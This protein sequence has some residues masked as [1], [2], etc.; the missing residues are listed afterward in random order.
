[1]EALGPELV[2]NEL[3]LVRAMAF[4][5]DIQVAEGTP[6][7][8][9][10][11]SGDEVQ[12][13]YVAQ[14]FVGAAVSGSVI[15]MYAEAAVRTQEEYDGEITINKNLAESNA[16]EVGRRFQFALLYG[17]SPYLSAAAQVD[18]DFHDI[19]PAANRIGDTSNFW[20]T[21]DSAVKLTNLPEHFFYWLV[22]IGDGMGDF[23]APLYNFR[24]GT[25][26]GGITFP[27]RAVAIDSPVSG[28]RTCHIRLDEATAGA[29][30][31]VTNTKEGE[32]AV[33]TG[34]D[35][36]LILP[37]TVV[38]F[39]LLCLAGAEFYRRKLNKRTDK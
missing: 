29:E 35:R 8:I 7:P 12:D 32:K 25:P 5:P 1:M 19:S 18:L 14:A 39:G 2:P 20:I 24:S 15:N 23:V 3:L 6:V 4:A 16:D 30:I 26:E 10:A 13:W 31:I 37:V 38:S 22:E 33:Q 36:N 34:D 11:L 9:A 27:A 21:S 17:A 28:Y